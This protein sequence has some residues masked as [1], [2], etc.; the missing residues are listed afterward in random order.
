ML[1]GRL[2]RRF[3]N[4][5]AVSPSTRLAQRFYAS[6]GHQPFNEPGGNLF[7]E[8]V[9]FLFFSFSLPWLM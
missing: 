4:A 9:S 8:P 1:I 6:H 5:I 3:P 7:G 2:S